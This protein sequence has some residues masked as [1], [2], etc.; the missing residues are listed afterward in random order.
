MC[1]KEAEASAA[2]RREAQRHLRQRCVVS[3]S[4]A[5]CPLAFPLTGIAALPSG[6]RLR[7]AKSV[8]CWFIHLH[9][10][11][12]FLGL[13]TLGGCQ[14]GTG[15]LLRKT[16]LGEFAVCVWRRAAGRCAA[17]AVPTGLWEGAGQEP[18]GGV[19]H[20]KWNDTFQTFSG[21]FPGHSL[22]HRYF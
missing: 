16:N 20:L 10:E 21:E 17:V 9:F 6:Q 18:D 19:C 8:T 13:W 2:A 15:A 7:R 22:N 14:L 5:S 3:G 4:A 11:L 1:R 12:A